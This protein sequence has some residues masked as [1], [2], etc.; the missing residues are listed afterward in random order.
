MF[1]SWRVCEASHDQRPDLRFRSSSPLDDGS[2]VGGGFLPQG[3]ADAYARLVPL[4]SWAST[5]G[6]SKAIDDG[7]VQRTCA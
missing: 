1:F 5:K 7:S 2:V 6:G 3:L 4:R